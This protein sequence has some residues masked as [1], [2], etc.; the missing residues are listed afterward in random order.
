MQK[1]FWDYSSKI[2]PLFEQNF[3]ITCSKFTETCSEFP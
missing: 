1:I 2:L 3:T